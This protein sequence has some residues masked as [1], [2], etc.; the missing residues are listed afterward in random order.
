M[1][2]S[3]PGIVLVIEIKWTVT[4]LLS[5]FSTIIFFSRVLYSCEKKGTI[6]M[7]RNEKDE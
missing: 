3:L 4:R 5:I 1:I 2:F 6:M 7:N